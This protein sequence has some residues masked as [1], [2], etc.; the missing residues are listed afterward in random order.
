MAGLTRRGFLATSAST[1]AGVAG[2]GALVASPRL[3]GAMTMSPS[4]TTAS[5]A[6]PLVAYV[7]DG[8]G[9][10]LVLMA[11]TREVS[12]HDPALVQRLYAAASGDHPASMSTR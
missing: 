10:E 2:V 7:R 3:R 4:S 12:L 6:Q 9:G 11:G 5:V 1:A 8:S